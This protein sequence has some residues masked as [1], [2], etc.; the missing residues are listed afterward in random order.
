MLRWT[1]I[2]LLTGLLA[3][4]LRAESAE[5]KLVFEDNFDRD[6]LGDA[7]FIRSGRATLVDGRLFLDGHGATLMPNRGFGPDV[8]VEF[9]A[10]VNPKAP[11]C[12]I[13]VGLGCDPLTGYTY[14]FQLG[15]RSNQVNAILAGAA[16]V[17]DESPPFLL[18]HDK[19][20]HCIAIKEGKRLAYIVNDT[21]LVENTNVPDPVAGPGFDHVALVTWN[22]M[23]VDW[24]RIYERTE[25][26]PDTPEYLTAM[27]DFGWRWESLTLSFDGGMEEGLG[28]VL[29]DYNDRRHLEA[30][31]R[32]RAMTEA[33]DPPH[34][35]VPVLMAYVVGDL[36]YDEKPEDQ[37]E[38][39]RLLEQAANQRPDGGGEAWRDFTTAARW[40]A[41]INL[42]SR[43]VRACMRL[44]Q[45]GPE[46]NPFY[47]K[48][49]FYL[50]RFHYAWAIEGADAR[51]RNEAI[52]MF[53]ELKEIW[54][55][56]QSLRE[57]TGERIPWGE[58]LIR[59]E[60]DGPSWA[61]HLQECLARQQ[62]ILNWWVTVR[63]FPDG[64]L[65]GG[66]GDDVEILRGWVPATCITTACETAIAGIERL[67]Q[68]VW[69]HVLKEGYSR[70]TGDV[71]HE[72]EPSADSLPTMLLLRYGDPKWVEYNLRSAKTI[73]EKFMALNE[74]GHLQFISTEFGTDEVRTAPGA[75]GDTGYHARALKHH[76]WLGWYGIPEAAD[77]FLA[78]CDTWRDATLR[79]IDSKPPGFP[80]AS[81]FYPSGGIDPPSGLPWYNAH[82]HYYGFPGLHNM[83]FDS[84]LSAYLLTGDPRWLDPFQTMMDKATTGPLRQQDPSLTPDHPDNLLAHMAHFPQAN[85]TSVY[86]LLTGERVYDA[87]TLRACTPT[88]RYRV[89]YDLD[90][91]AAAFERVVRPLRF[92]WTQHTVEVI[93]TDRAGLAGANQVLGAYTGAVRDF[94][95][96]GAPT[97]AVTWD[98]PDLNFAA[99]VTEARPERLRVRLYSFNESV[100]RIGLRPWRLAP[101]RYVL[102]Q[103]EPTEAER[104]FLDRHAWEP[105][106]EVEHIHRGTA[107]W[108]DVPPGREW[109]VDLRLREPIERPDLLPDLAIARRDCRLLAPDLLEVT[110][111]NIGGAPA[112]PY[113]VVVQVRKGEEWITVGERRSS[114]PPPIKNLE[115]STQTIAI[116][117]EERIDRGYRV[118]I[119]PDE[120][121]DEI[122]RGN[123]VV[124]FLDGGH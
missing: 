15:G 49:K 77:V 13:S 96:S 12:D 57:F 24:V 11:P 54:P 20:Y 81:I 88:Q 35:D 10:D 9:I 94:R 113:R 17:I 70:Y 67:A 83:I 86:R 27:P 1:S 100:T 42:F 102:N 51:R 78:W 82:A 33:S 97:M 85:H 5:W 110:L 46:N 61:R 30:I 58:E 84:F 3:S 29:D 31:R 26:T 25:P 18:E 2:F 36:A 69:D 73:R 87:Y 122:Y 63:Q 40:F 109:T 64:Q 50:A 124:T 68:G 44:V 101:G 74:R 91:Y 4:S 90:A 79:Q 62:A 41:G 21:L 43:D 16:S 76:L 95:D 7:W 71:E 38:I 22:G 108:I 98:T 75:G 93:Q 8:K 121:I 23:Y 45:L 60:S 106:V 103:G 89:D 59:P 119:D 107:I 120:A 52:E 32:L 114:G 80:P 116:L 53:N 28:R 14:L 105:S 37:H 112:G 56:H 48:A 111:H 47:H 123:N 34:P 104:P 117:C 92:N 118:V 39:V 99:L 65:G 72:A 115:P 6:E 66:W 19:R 55:E